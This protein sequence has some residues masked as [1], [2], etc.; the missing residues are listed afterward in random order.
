[1]RAAKHH[2][3]IDRAFAC[4]EDGQPISKKAL[5]KQQKEAEK[6]AK[7][8]QRAQE[9]SSN[10]KKKKKD[11][12]MKKGKK[13]EKLIYKVVFLFGMFRIRS[14]FDHWPSVSAKTSVNIF[15]ASL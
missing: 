10:R 6:A 11:E 13:G 8:A 15:G 4:R 1:M 7:K 9:V 3:A 12:E 14:V 5:K 2:S